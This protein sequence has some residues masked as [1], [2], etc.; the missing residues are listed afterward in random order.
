VRVRGEEEER[1]AEAEDDREAA[2]AR[3]SGRSTRPISSAATF[4]IRVATNDVTADARKRIAIA[5]NA[6]T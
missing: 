6:S 2:D 3:S 1:E 5:T 4:V